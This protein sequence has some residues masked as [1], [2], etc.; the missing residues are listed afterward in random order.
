MYRIV[1]MYSVSIYIYIYSIDTQNMY[2]I[3]TMYPG[4]G[5]QIKR[6]E[7]QEKNKPGSPPL[8][9]GEMLDYRKL[10]KSYIFCF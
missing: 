5:M 2:I 10:H 7:R 9:C 6:N 8:K 4:P 1:Y 3:Y